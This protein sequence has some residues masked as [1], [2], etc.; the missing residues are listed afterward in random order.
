MLAFLFPAEVNSWRSAVFIDL[1]FTL[2]SVD[3]A[4]EDLTGLK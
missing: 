2:E 4:S 3:D 1:E